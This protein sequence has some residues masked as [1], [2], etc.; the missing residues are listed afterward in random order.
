M[1]LLNF[2]GI[3]DSIRWQFLDKHQGKW[4]PLDKDQ[5]DIER[6]SL[7][8][9]PLREKQLKILKIRIRSKRDKSKKAKE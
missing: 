8:A 3:E 1:A 2:L 5:A 4:T 9:E 7:Y 6:F